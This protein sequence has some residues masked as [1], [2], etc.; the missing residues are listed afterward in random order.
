M[1]KIPGKVILVKFWPSAP[2]KVLNIG[3]LA[4]DVNLTGKES[5]YL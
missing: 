3:N 1:L 4:S 2:D 5:L